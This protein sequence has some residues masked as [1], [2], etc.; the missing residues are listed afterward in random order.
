MRT[1]DYANKAKSIKNKPVVLLDPQQVM[2]RSI[3]TITHHTFSDTDT[4]TDEK[5]DVPLR[6]PP[7]GVEIVIGTELV[8][9]RMTFDG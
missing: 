3:S 8:I 5:G 6:L 1:L 4:D 9:G 2:S 7:G